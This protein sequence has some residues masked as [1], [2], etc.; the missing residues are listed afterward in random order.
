MAHQ[1]SNPEMPFLLITREMVKEEAK[2]L[3]L[4]RKV[5]SLKEK[6]ETLILLEKL[7]WMNLGN[8]RLLL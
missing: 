4:R 3:K 7:K 6:K 8:N 2:W 5:T 1:S